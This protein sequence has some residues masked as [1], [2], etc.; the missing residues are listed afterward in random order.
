[1]KN[2]ERVIAHFQEEAAR[3]DGIIIQLIPYYPQ[4]VEALILSIPFPKGEP[5]RVLD[6]GCGTGTI[7]HRIKSEFPHARITCLDI[8]VNMIEVA[9]S[10]LSPYG[11]VEYRVADFNNFEFAGKYDMVVSS[12]ALHH[13]AD[14]AAKIRLYRKIFQSLSDGGIFYNADVILASNDHLQ[15]INMQK[16][17]E[18]MN[19]AVPMDEVENK[20]LVTYREED[21]PARLM[22]QLEWLKEIGFTD[23]DVVW[24]YYNFAVY[25]GYKKHC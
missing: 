14:D 9:K 18:Y 17:V 8:A 21:R 22:I 5:I 23:V 15:A 19:R 25:G 6:L 10:K 2:M 3:F 13:L 1:M 11:D 20:W 24:K 7:A 16:W 4:M 12:L